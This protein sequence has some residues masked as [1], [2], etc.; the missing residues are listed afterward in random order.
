MKQTIVPAQVTTIED[1][2]MG[3][4][5]LSQLLLLVT[6]IFAGSAL[7][8]V[9]PPVAHISTYKLVILTVLVLSCASLAIRIRGKIILLWLVVL[10]RFYLRPGYFIFN[11]LSLSNREEYIKTKHL[12]NE[13]EDKSKPEPIRKHL[14]LSTAQIVKLENLIE[15]PSANLS[16]ESKK[17]NLYVHITEVK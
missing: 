6:P 4:I 7:Y 11:R 2:I 14:T 15:N 9:L 3:S 8:F 16:F 10:L 12:E 5:G 17:G 1:R 13:T